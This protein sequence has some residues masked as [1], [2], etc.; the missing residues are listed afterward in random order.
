MKT[1]KLLIF[2]CL[3]ISVLASLYSC[4]NSTTPDPEMPPTTALQIAVEGAPLLLIYNWNSG[5]HSLETKV[6]LTENAGASTTISSIDFKFL[7]SG[8]VSEI[9]TLPGGNLAA[10]GKF[11]IDVNLDILDIHDA[12][13]IDVA[14][15]SANNQQITA[16]KNVKI[17]YI[18]NLHG[19]YEGPSLGVQGGIK[20]TKNLTLDI[21]Q[22][23][24]ILTGSWAIADGGPSGTLSGTIV[25]GEISAILELVIPC[26]GLLNVDAA[27][28][29][30]GLS[31]KGLYKG[32]TYCIGDME[33]DFSV[34]RQ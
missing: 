6:T 27:I 16:S 29:G 32:T 14:G 21:I 10:N 9:R 15:S 28:E 31:F 23:G 7:K 11:S 17:E 19:T 24:K 3:G 20:F 18:P 25:G 12:L 1:T 8:A 22:D 33:G 2:L 26:A 34:N 5:S 30:N 13:S 4:G